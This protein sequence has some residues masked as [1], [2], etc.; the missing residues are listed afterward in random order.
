[1]SQMARHDFDE[2][3][4]DRYGPRIPKVRLHEDDNIWVA[5][6][7]KPTSHHPQG[8]HPMLI[9][10]PVKKLFRK[11]RWERIP[12]DPKISVEQ[13]ERWAREAIHYINANLDVDFPHA[14]RFFDVDRGNWITFEDDKIPKY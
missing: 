12:D 13:V 1:M 3:P 6:V 14:L 8:G 10:R 11:V 5:W 7:T 9:R 2:Y 4:E